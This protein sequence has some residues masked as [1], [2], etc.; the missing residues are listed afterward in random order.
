MLK[1]AKNPL[2]LVVFAN[3]LLAFTSFGR[4]LPVSFGW[5][6]SWDNYAHD[7]LIYKDFF[8]PYPPVGLFLNGTL[9][10]YFGN[11]IY[12][13]LIIE[14]LT[15]VLAGT[16]LYLV[17][18]I[19]FRPS[20][21]AGV[22]IFMAVAY[23]TRP[24]KV[25]A[26]YFEISWA[27]AIFAIWL[28]FVG[29]SKSNSRMIFCAG[30]LLALSALTKQT[31]LIQ[32]FLV[33]LGF[34]YAVMQTPTY[35]HKKRISIASMMGWVLP[36]LLV[37]VWA[38][39]QGVLVEMV[40]SVLSGG[41]KEPNLSK[42]LKWSFGG[43]LTAG[44][45]WVAI[46]IFGSLILIGRMQ[47]FENST[48]KNQS[49][50]VAGWLG[51]AGVFVPEILIRLHVISN[52]QIVALAF[53]FIALLLAFSSKFQESAGQTHEFRRSS[54]LAVALVITLL[55][56]DFIADLVSTQ[57]YVELK[58]QLLS[59]SFAWTILVALIWFSR[60]W[61]KVERT[62]YISGKNSKF[63]FTT[64]ILYCAGGFFINSLSGGVD[65]ENM[66]LLI[67]MM[68]GAL[69]SMIMGNHRNH[70]LLP[71]ML[72]SSILM[73]FAFV[74]TWIA[75]PYNWWGLTH[76]SIA[77]SP[78]IAP[79]VLGMEFLNLDSESAQF[80]SDYSLVMSSLISQNPTA[81]AVYG[82]QILGLSLL[83][84][85]IV[86]K[87]NCPVM[88]F[89]VCPEDLARKDLDSFKINPPEIVVWA[90]PP[91]FAI[92]GHES[93]FRDSIGKSSIRSMEIWLKEQ[94]NSN[95]YTSV[96]RLPAPGSKDQP[97]GAEVEDKSLRTSWILHVYIRNSEF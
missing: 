25:I 91:E 35:Q 75:I 41:G 50:A 85:A 69:V 17:T 80:Y 96:L 83:D 31:F 93:A 4:V 76:P 94:E 47:V 11:P 78:R 67:T 3:T 62:F 59:L 29:A 15:W 77:E 64:I 56:V 10:N 81:Q 1:L 7:H 16:S 92:V 97:D 8:F 58:S 54:Q 65:T 28:L 22:S 13:E 38:I 68:L 20:V 14:L 95:L 86:R 46:F 36:F 73:T 71:T 32:N 70:P 79:D 61:E 55:V 24:I 88:W 72:A 63:V 33:L 37:A 51:F 90:S 27:F 89:D 66:V 43:G 39:S 49:V 18:K 44:P 42:L 12:A 82:P 48:F 5:F 23:Y 26:G 9:P 53:L 60:G 2:T 19:F 6:L 74:A 52:F 40:N 45:G 84:E 87:V 21:A 57:I 34:L 30:I